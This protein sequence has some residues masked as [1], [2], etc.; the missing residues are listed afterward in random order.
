MTCPQAGH[1]PFFPSRASG[2][3]NWVLQ[4]GLGHCV[5][6]VTRDYSWDFLGGSYR[7]SGG[8]P[9]GRGGGSFSSLLASSARSSSS[10]WRQYS[11]QK[12]LSPLLSRSLLFSPVSFSSALS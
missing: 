2:T 10:C 8:R 7:L 3:S 9:A 1:G 5:N 11:R 12:L 6:T 4:L